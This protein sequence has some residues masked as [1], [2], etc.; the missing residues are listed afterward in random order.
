MSGQSPTTQPSSDGNSTTSHQSE[1]KPKHKPPPVRDDCWSEA[2]TFTLIESW[3][4]KILKL[5]TGS[6]RQQHWQEV[7][8][9]VNARHGHVKKAR[10]TDVQCK[11]R[12]DT[13]KKKYK[14]EKGLVLQLGSDNYTSPWPFFSPLDS[15]IGSTFKPTAPATV[16]RKPMSPPEK[17][18]LLL[19][20]LPSS[21]PVG[22]RS[23]RPPPQP[24]FFQRN[25]SVMAAVDFD[26]SSSGGD[27]KRSRL[28]EKDDPYGQLAEAIG[29]FADVYARVEESKQRQ[30]VELEKQ[31]M[32]FTKDLELEK[33]KLL[34]ESQV[35]LRKLKAASVPEVMSRLA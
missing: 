29:W 7:A 4:D 18:P 14:V 9:A 13:L 34:M 26:T 25:F 33:M 17:T 16:K 8:D 27:R 21:V 35:Q 19:P 23:K 20:P 3:G 6:L 1:T 5:N 2:A 30:M 31:R 12:I 11:N 32:Q 22:R 28:P 10:R 15:V 24:S